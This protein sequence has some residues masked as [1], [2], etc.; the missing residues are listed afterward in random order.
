MY[1]PFD[2]ITIY[3][4]GGI[5]NL[6]DFEA[7]GWRERVKEHYYN[8]VNVTL[9]D[10]MRRDYRGCD[11]DDALS[12]KIV[13]EDKND[14]NNSDIVLAYC[15]RPSWGTAMEIIYACERDKW[16]I[17]VTEDPNPSP[18][19]VE[20]SDYMVST[21]EEAYPVIADISLDRQ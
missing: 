9:L 8:S 15:P 21:L 10:P 12:H 4:C 20:H 16:V 18:W 6:T 7:K 17:V 13:K 1:R 11:C 19:L 2:G 5:A 14:I 3:L